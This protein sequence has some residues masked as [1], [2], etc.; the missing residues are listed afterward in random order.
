MPPKLIFALFVLF[1]LACFAAVLWGVW[2]SADML[3]PESTGEIG[4]MG[5]VVIAKYIRYAVGA[6]TAIA[7]ASAVSA[8]LIYV[9]GLVAAARSPGTEAT[10]GDTASPAKRG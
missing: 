4:F 6:L 2:P 3:A 5:M 7:T 1:S 10:L 8:G 9:G